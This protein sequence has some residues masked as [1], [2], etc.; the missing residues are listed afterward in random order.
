VLFASFRD[1]V[2]RARATEHAELDKGLVLLHEAMERSRLLEE[3]MAARREAAMKEVEEIRVSTAD[4]AEEI[5][6]RARTIAGEI[7]AQARTEAMEITAT[8]CQRIPLT[9]GPPNPAPASE[10]ASRVA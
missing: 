1:G 7:L 5:L 8:A 10:E 6:A 9:V 2:T 4:E 3:R